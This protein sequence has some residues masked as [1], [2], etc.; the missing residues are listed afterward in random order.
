MKWIGIILS[1][2]VKGLEAWNSYRASKLAKAE[3]MEKENENTIK[4]LK[5]RD[6][7]NES[8]VDSMLKDPR[9]R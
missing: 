9:D 5:A 1:V 4:G 7:V 8:N 3:I 2:L 6:S